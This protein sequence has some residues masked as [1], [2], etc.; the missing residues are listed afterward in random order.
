VLAARLHHQWL[1][2]QVTVEPSVEP[3]LV[4]GLKALGH[5]VVPAP[6]GRL[7][8]ANCIE[9]VPRTGGYRAVADITRGGGAAL[10]Y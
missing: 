3:A 10:A 9:V 4:D 2:D 5:K 8:H 7:G 6:F 1:P